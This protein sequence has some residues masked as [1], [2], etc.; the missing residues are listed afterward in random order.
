MCQVTS[1][2]E[3][4]VG[5]DKLG[6][7]PVD[8]QDSPYYGSVPPCGVMSAQLECIYYTKFVR[9]L[10]KKVPWSLMTLIDRKKPGDWYT[11]H[12]VLFMMLHS[13]SMTSRRDMEYAATLNLP[14]RDEIEG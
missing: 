11:I 4:I 8:D 2:F 7:S 6:V 5:D 3:H 13:C 10:S 14:V 12:L 9:P 1:N